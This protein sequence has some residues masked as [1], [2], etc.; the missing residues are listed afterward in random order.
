MASFLFKVKIKLRYYRNFI[1][2]NFFSKK[3]TSS[4]ADIILYHAFDDRMLV[5]VSRL[6]D[7]ENYYRG[8][9]TFYYQNQLSLF[10]QGGSFNSDLYNKNFEEL[11][12]SYQSGGYKQESR[13]IID[14]NMYLFNGTHRTAMNLYHNIYTINV[15]LIPRKVSVHTTLY[16]FE[17]GLPDICNAIKI[18]YDVLCKDLVSSGHCLCCIANNVNGD[19]YELLVQ[20]IKEYFM[21][22]QEDKRGVSILFRLSSEYPDFMVRHH[23]LVSK[24]AI[25]LKNNLLQSFDTMSFKVSENSIEGEKLVSEWY[26]IKLLK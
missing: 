2:D 24:R 3:C 17:K 21:I 18:R 26:K 23:R 15:S 16:Q 5:V 12:Q 13:I 9:K 25:L 7:I 8:D 19:Q 4:I 22:I 20:V 6:M 11:I 14:R 10:S 1:L